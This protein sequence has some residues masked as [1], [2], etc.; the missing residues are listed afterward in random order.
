MIRVD[1][2]GVVT[3]VVPKGELEDPIGVVFDMLGNL[4]VCEYSSGN[5]KRISPGGKVSTLSFVDQLGQPYNFKH[6]VGM[7]VDATGVYVTEQ[8]KHEIA[9]ISMPQEW[10]TSLHSHFP[11]DTRIQIKTL[12]MLTMKKGHSN[13][14]MWRLPKDIW[15]IVIRLVASQRLEKK[16]VLT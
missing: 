6:P 1:R 10:S 4:L 13:S 11:S 8:Y 15:L 12:V 14:H 7:A 2:N 9:F 5:I 16:V 3:P